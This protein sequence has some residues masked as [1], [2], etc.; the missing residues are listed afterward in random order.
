MDWQLEVLDHRLRRQQSLAAMH[1]VQT[2][3]ELADDTSSLPIIDQVAEHAEASVNSLEDGPSSS[4]NVWQAA[5]AARQASMHWSI[6]PYLYF[7]QE[8]TLVVFSYFFLPT[9]L[10]LLLSWS[11][12]LK[13]S[14][15][16]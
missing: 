2:L 5:K 9:S 6:L 15:L 4:Q 10:H 13:R 11:R 16:V 3:V 7:P 12:V 14:I 8:F 1:D